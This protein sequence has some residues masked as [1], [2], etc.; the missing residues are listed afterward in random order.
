MFDAHADLF[1]LISI[2]C[3]CF[4]MPLAMFAGHA[5]INR[6][7]EKVIEPYV[8]HAE[9]LAV[10]ARADALFDKGIGA[11]A[12]AFLPELQAK[13]LTVD[14]DASM[15]AHVAAYLINHAP[16]FADQIKGFEGGLEQMASARLITHPAVQAAIA[17]V[18]T[19]DVGPA[20]AAA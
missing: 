9:A 16:D 20:A 2:V 7:V 1:P 6:G 5:L 12:M 3:T 13:G 19:N 10:Q 18:P 4:V 8:G 17:G 15:A 11:A 14:L